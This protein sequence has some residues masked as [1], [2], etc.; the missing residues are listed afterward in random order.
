MK[1]VKITIISQNANTVKEFKGDAA[2]LNA[3]TYL[4]SLC[5]SIATP[6]EELKEVEKPETTED[7]EKNQPIEDV[8]EDEVE[9]DDEIV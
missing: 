9:G 3:Y 7:G 4:A 8:L 6:T 1:E 2:I 5:P